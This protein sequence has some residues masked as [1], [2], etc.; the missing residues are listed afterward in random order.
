MIR[1]RRCATWSTNG[2]DLQPR[3][4]VILCYLNL[5]SLTLL[6]LFFHYLTN[7]LLQIFSTYLQLIFHIKYYIS[8]FFYS[9]IIQF[10]KYILY[11]T[12]TTPTKNYIFKLS[13]KKNT[14]ITTN[15]NYT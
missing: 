10:T 9:T 2:A 7:L 4:A 5:L 11:T 13:S 15:T 1:V 12:K 14:L 8:M 6:F 3:F